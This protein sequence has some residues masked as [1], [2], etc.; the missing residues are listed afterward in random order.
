MSQIV[1]IK[2][3][4]LS[5][6]MTRSILIITF[7]GRDIQSACAP[8]ARWQRG[9]TRDVRKGGSAR[10]VLISGIQ[11]EYSTS[12]VAWYHVVS[13]NYD[14]VRRSTGY[15]RKYRRSHARKVKTL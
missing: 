9:Y 11:R 15:T 7:V 5:Y 12:H 13:S 1:I 3:Y 4:E 6:S 8:V 10:P 14:D 2:G